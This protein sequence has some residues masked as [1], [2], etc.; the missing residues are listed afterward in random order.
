MPQ[1]KQRLT[2]AQAH[3]NFMEH[4]QARRKAVFNRDTWR[5]I[6]NL[7]QLEAAAWKEYIDALKRERT[8]KKAK[9]YPPERP[10]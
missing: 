6:G 5:V 8:D 9:F 2:S 4:Y 1:V 10:I 7:A 3:K